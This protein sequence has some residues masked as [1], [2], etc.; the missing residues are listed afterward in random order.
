M[1]HARL[2][3]QIQRNWRRGGAKVH[4]P[5]TSLELGDKELTLKCRASYLRVMRR[6]G[7]SANHLTN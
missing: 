4:R 2:A 6:Y 7:Y 3:A 5:E 1:T